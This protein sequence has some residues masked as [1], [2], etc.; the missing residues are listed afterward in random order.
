MTAPVPEEAGPAVQTACEATAA[1]EWGDWALL[2]AALGAAGVLYGWLHRW[3]LRRRLEWKLGDVRYT[4]ADAAAG[5]LSPVL[6]LLWANYVPDGSAAASWADLVILFSP[7]A[8]A[9]WWRIAV[10]SG[11]YLATY[12]L[13]ADLCEA[14]M[15]HIFLVRHF[16]LARLEDTD[17]RCDGAAFYVKGPFDA[18]DVRRIGDL[19]AR[20]YGLAYPVTVETTLSE[21]AYWRPYREELQPAG[22]VSPPMRPLEIG[23]IPVVAVVAGAAAL[24]AIAWVNN[25]GIGLSS[26]DLRFFMKSTAGRV[27]GSDRLPPEALALQGDARAESAPFTIDLEGSAQACPEIIRNAVARWR[28]DTEAFVLGSLG[29]SVARIHYLDGTY[30]L[31]EIDRTSGRCVRETAYDTLAD[32]RQ[33]AQRFALPGT[34]RK[35]PAGYDWRQVPPAKL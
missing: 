8:F 6:A 12:L 22:Y 32:A 7:V 1:I 4:P 2:A 34:W 33:A 10:F 19:V 23:L 30:F 16:R 35:I 14:A 13:S 25:P 9:T 29:R 15:V 3:S 31:F 21:E 20:R 27:A 26:E 5:L 11:I 28:L 24:I 18:V 17:V